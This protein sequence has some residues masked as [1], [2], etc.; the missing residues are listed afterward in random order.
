MAKRGIE[1]NSVIILLQNVPN[2]RNLRE[3]RSNFVFENANSSSQKLA[4]VYMIYLLMLSCY[5]IYCFSKLNFR[6]F[7]FVGTNAKRNKFE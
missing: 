7:K 5:F 4:F 1:Q 3:K 2:I 6:F